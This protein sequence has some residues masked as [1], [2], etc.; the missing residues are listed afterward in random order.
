MF[1]RIKPDGDMC[2]KF[3]KELSGIK[4]DPYF[5]AKYKLYQ[6]PPNPSK[7][8]TPE[9]WKEVHKMITRPGK[10]KYVPENVDIVYKGEK[11]CIN[12][13]PTMYN[14]GEEYTLYHS[15]DKVYLK[16]QTTVDILLR[17]RQPKVD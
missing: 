15:I 8:L 13:C 11:K 3:G 9:E 16:P 10:N 17:I 2:A 14:F 6:R 12:E 1:D 4:K 7:S 5:N